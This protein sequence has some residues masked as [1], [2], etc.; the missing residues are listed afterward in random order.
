MGEFFV[1]GRGVYW[2]LVYKLA[3]GTVRISEVEHGSLGAI[4]GCRWVGLS[5]ARTPSYML[6]R[7]ECAAPAV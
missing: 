4:G 6:D 1:L 3:V 2:C 5:R 7:Y